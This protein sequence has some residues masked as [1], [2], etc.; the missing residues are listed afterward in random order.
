MTGAV[1]SGSPT[2]MATCSTSAAASR[3]STNRLS[4]W[5]ASG[6]GASLT[7]INVIARSCGNASRSAT[8]TASNASSPPPCTG[9]GTTTIA[10][11]SRASRA[12]SSAAAHEAAAGPPAA[13]MRSGS[14]DC[15]AALPAPGSRPESGASPASAARRSTSKPAGRRTT[16]A[17]PGGG[18]GGTPGAALP[19]YRLT[20]TTFAGSTRTALRGQPSACARS[21]D[22][23]RRMSTGSDANESG[24]SPG[25]AT[26]STFSA[27]VRGASG[28]EAACL[29]RSGTAGVSSACHQTGD[30]V[31][32]AATISS[33]A[34]PP[35]SRTGLPRRSS[36]SARSTRTVARNAER[37]G[38]P[39][40][41]KC[42][43]LC[44]GSAGDGPVEEL[45]RFIAL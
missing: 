11:T 43:A 3:K 19:W 28:A 17:V 23:T 40:S 45:S 24:S 13:P 44:A 37:S 5:P 26:D 6:T 31:S 9:A 38:P 12:I 4:S 32:T 7:R 14:N 35:V 2:T 39:P 16:T 8:S 41:A 1:G 15:K 21:A 10:G 34:S 36:V 18:A 42:G 22:R 29:S 33:P 30:K 27:R 20:D 25:P